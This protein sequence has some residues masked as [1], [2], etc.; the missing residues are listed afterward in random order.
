ML[1][2]NGVRPGNGAEAGYVAQRDLVSTVVKFVKF[3]VIGGLSA[4]IFVVVYIALRALWPP[5]AANLAGLLTA[6]IFNTEA[7]R[8]W[9]F[10]RS[11]V[12]RLRMHIKGAAL[13]LVAYLFT[14]SAVLALRALHPHAD[15]LTEAAVIVVANCAM[16]VFRFVGLDRW[17]IRP[18]G[19][20]AGTSV[21]P[22]P[23]GTD[24]ATD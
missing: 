7:N 12:S 24:V 13:I 9:T 22:E 6:V 20:S 8:H 16:V 17:A 19:R 15:R 5:P 1:C 18:G 3:S 21:R 2:R 10:E 4:L 14:T 23:G 11:Q